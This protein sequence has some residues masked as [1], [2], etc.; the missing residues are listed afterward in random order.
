MPEQ[1]AFPDL[2]DAMKKRVMWREQIL[3]E[4]DAVVSWT[5]LLALIEPHY[6]K[7]GP[8][9]R[10][11]PMSLATMLRVCFLQYRYA[12][13]NPMAEGMHYDREAMRRFA[14]I[15]FNFRHLLERHGLTEA[16]FAQVNAHHADKGIA[17]CSGALAD[18]ERA[19]AT[20]SS[21]PP[22]SIDAPCSTKNKAGA[23]DTEMSFTN[24]GNTWFFGIKALVGVD[25]ESGVTRSL[26]TSTDKLHDSQVWDDVL[27]SQKSSVWADEG[28][29]SAEREAAFVAAGG[30]RGVMPKEPKGGQLDSEDEWIKRIISTVRA[31]IKHPFRVFKRHFGHVKT[32]YRGLAKNRAQLCTVFALGKLF[33]ARRRLLSSRRVCL[34]AARPP[35]ELAR[36]GETRRQSANSRLTRR[37]SRHLG[38]DQRVDQTVQRTA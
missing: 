38:A 19:N 18:G 6:P 2:P 25:A 22:N 31:K 37:S 11:P 12:L 23:R 32:R 9:R 34:E 21:E 10:R 28:Y 20:R 26:Q 35:Y 33:V 3:A 5:R 1:P 15:K 29:V 17:L 36:N 27:H 14:G 7:A 4:M 16:I 13:S 24:K 8:K 30:A